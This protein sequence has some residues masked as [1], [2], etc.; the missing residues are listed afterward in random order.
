MIEPSHVIEFPDEATE[1]LAIPRHPV[2]ATG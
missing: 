2:T 1:V